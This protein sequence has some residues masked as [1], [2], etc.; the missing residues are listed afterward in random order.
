MKFKNIRESTK[1][2]MTKLLF[3][4][5]VDEIVKKQKLN[6]TSQQRPNSFDTPERD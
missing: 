4:T 6:R 5:S 2:Q 3:T 1:H